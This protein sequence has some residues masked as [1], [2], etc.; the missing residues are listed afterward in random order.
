MSAIREVLDETHRQHTTTRRAE[1]VIKVHQTILDAIRDGDSREA[2]RLMQEHIG[3][4][5]RQTADQA[6]PQTARIAKGD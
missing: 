2:G 4:A 3:L 5:R 1:R 6:Q